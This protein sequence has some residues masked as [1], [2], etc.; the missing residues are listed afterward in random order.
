MDDFAPEELF[1]HRTKLKRLSGDVEDQVNKCN[2][3]MCDLI[4]LQR[5]VR[6]EFSIIALSLS[7]KGGYRKF[8]YLDWETQ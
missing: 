7:I 2:A 1:Q 6:F 5:S 8:S 4:Y 3:P